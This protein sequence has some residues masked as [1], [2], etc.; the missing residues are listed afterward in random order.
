MDFKLNAEGWAD[1][2]YLN[3]LVKEYNSC[4]G[5]KNKSKKVAMLIEIHIFSKNLYE[6]LHE[7]DD[8]LENYWCAEYIRSYPELMNQI[9]IELQKLE[10]PPI[11]GLAAEKSPASLATINICVP[12]RNEWVQKTTPKFRKRGE[13]YQCIDTLLD[14]VQSTKETASLSKN[15]QDIARY[16]NTLAELQSKCVY[17]LASLS[18][19][20]LAAKK[21]RALLL[22]VSHELNHWTQE[23]QK[24]S[25]EYKTR[26]DRAHELLGNTFYCS[27]ISS[28]ITL[29]NDLGDSE[30]CTIANFELTKL[31]GGNTKVW[32]ASHSENDE[33]FLIRWMNKADLKPSILNRVSS[34]PEIRP[35]L[36]E[37]YI[38][39]PAGV[40]Q[41][42]VSCVIS[43]GEFCDNGSLVKELEAISKKGAQSNQLIDNALDKTKQVAS[44]ID[45]L[46]KNQLCYP[47]IKADNFLVNKN[48]DVVVSDLKFI[49]P[50]DENQCIIGKFHTTYECAAPE[51]T[52][53]PLTRDK[54]NTESYTSYQLGV[55]FY[56]L[57]AENIGDAR[58]KF[59]S[60][61]KTASANKNPISA[62]NFDTP[63][64]Q[65]DAGR[66]AKSL[67][68][69]CMSTDP[70]TRPKIN[71]ILTDIQ[72]IQNKRT[73]MKEHKS[74]IMKEIL[75]QMKKNPEEESLCINFSRS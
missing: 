75:R 39:Y 17:Q 68:T 69:K 54:I 60:N 12:T 38:H 62:L 2:E 32:L 9:S 8:P 7:N 6:D 30:S 71:E 55:L 31:A 3:N 18:H 37:E 53:Q 56:E 28:L 11:L 41:E 13:H 10:H 57:L 73:E 67:I 74:I 1:F 25:G 26:L 14:M 16:C 64:F 34:N 50:I 4:D 72:E 61:L 59:L 70:A 19:K 22:E 35:Y 65:S 52:D 27:D 47:D 15:S 49:R 51:Y 33:K 29:R 66:M 5:E 42:T 20:N 46:A 44:F 58:L 48:G 36:T 43:V 63:V 40:F 21:Y 24:N 23:L 45:V